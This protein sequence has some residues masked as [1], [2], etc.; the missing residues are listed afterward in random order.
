MPFIVDCQRVSQLWWIPSSSALLSHLIFTKV[1]SLITVLHTTV[2]CCYVYCC[3]RD[4]DVTV[5]VPMG[6]NWSSSTRSTVLINNSASISTQIN[7][8]KGYH[9][10]IVHFYLRQG[11]QLHPVYDSVV[12]TNLLHFFCRPSLLDAFQQL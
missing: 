9:R 10:L 4:D 5:G 6:Y 2:V 11:L 1:S 8:Y 3:H 7:Y 12:V